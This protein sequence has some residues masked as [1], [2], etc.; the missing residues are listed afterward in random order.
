M[1]WGTFA[2]PYNR[3][4]PPAVIGKTSRVFPFG[5]SFNP[6][7]IVLDVP[8]FF[9]RSCE[10]GVGPGAWRTGLCLGPSSLLLSSL[11]NCSGAPSH[12]T[13]EPS[14]SLQAMEWLRGL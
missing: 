2:T 4:G 6:R 5:E 13:Q 11:I 12:L 10:S 3:Q 7:S 8:Q 1:T 14:L 9:R